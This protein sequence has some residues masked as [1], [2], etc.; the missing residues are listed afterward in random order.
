MDLKSGESRQLTEAVA[1]DVSSLAFLPGERG[2]LHFDNGVLMETQFG[3]RQSL[4]T[5]E[6]YR[7]PQGW[8]KTPETSYT[9]DGQYA[10]FVEKRESRYRLQVVRIANGQTHTVI[11]AANEIRDPLVRPKHSSL[12]A[13]VGGQPT[14]INFDGTGGRQLKLAAGEIGH[15]QFLE[16]GRALA[17]LHRPSDGKR[18]TS[19]R[20]FDLD[21]ATDSRIADTS[22]YIHFHATPD[23]SMFVGASGSKASPYVLLLSRAG[24]REFTLAEHRASDAAMVAPRF[25]YNSQAILFISDRHGKPAIY[26][27]PVDK[28]VAETDGS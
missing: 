19:L 7:T 13:R 18:L 1:L 14:S 16:D 4:K 2:F 28:L 5:R 21:A 17:Y 15:A 8:E 9:E 27:M 23:A 11:E 6:V 22:Q 20:E 26:M 25:T 10:A 12:F 3:R 24:K